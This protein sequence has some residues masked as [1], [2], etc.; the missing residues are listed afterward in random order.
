MLLVPLM[1]L[2]MNQC[3]W[4]V[5]EDRNVTGGYL[6]CGRATVIGEVY[7]REHKRMAHPPEGGRLWVSARLSRRRPMDDYAT[8]FAA[9]PPLIPYLQAEGIRTLRRAVLW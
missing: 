1:N 8:P 9:V 2:G 3:R 6:F 5:V 4:P 7:C